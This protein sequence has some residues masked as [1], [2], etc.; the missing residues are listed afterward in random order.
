[1]MLYENEKLVSDQTEVCN[2]FNKYFVN[3]AKDIDKDPP[4]LSGILKPPNIEKIMENNPTKD[5]ESQFSFKPTTETY[6]RKV[7]SNSG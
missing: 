1:M 5:P 3:I 4:I 7:I 2:I 6:I